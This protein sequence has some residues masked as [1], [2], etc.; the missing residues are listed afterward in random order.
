MLYVTTEF[1][2]AQAWAILGWLEVVRETK[3]HVERLRMVA[4]AWDFAWARVLV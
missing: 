3:S 4:M 1:S 2:P